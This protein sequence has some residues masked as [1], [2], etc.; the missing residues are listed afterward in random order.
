MI[1]TTFTRALSPIRTSGCRLQHYYR[2]YLKWSSAAFA[3]QSAFHS[4]RSSVTVQNRTA[5]PPF[6]DFPPDLVLDA[7]PTRTVSTSIS[8]QLAMD[9]HRHAQA[10]SVMSGTDSSDEV[11]SDIGSQSRA[12]STT[13]VS[14]QDMPDDILHH[15][16]KLSPED[17]HQSRKLSSLGRRKHPER[18]KDAL[19]FSSCCKNFR[20]SVFQDLLIT[21]LMVDFS[22]EDLLQLESVSA[23]LRGHVR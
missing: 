13:S 21:N 10:S 8:H 20:R 12:L 5:P 15:I 4:I 19:A 3:N 17:W 18:R 9:Q 7:R 23:D 14:L 16:A 11:I 6:L 22:Y 2:Q 1:S